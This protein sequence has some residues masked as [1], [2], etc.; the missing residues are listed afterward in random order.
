MVRDENR[1]P[2]ENI[3]NK[4]NENIVKKLIKDFIG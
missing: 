4:S 2:E 1:Y 3:E